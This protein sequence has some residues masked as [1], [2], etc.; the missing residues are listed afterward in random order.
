MID[1]NDSN[2]FRIKTNK[3]VSKV[4]IGIHILYENMRASYISSTT[5]FKCTLI[6]GSLPSVTIQLLLLLRLRLLYYTIT[7]I[8][9]PRSGQKEGQYDA[10]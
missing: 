9:L 5:N 6:N 7:I 3:Q 8:L 2:R 10:S 1:D 4:C